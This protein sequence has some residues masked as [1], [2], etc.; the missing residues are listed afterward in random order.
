MAVTLGQGAVGREA[1]AELARVTGADVVASDDLTGS[2]DHGGDW[3]LEVVE[4]N[5]RSQGI[6]GDR[7]PGGVG[8]I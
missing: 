6:R 7:V 3:D 4:G 5:D 2:Q 1:A 8:R